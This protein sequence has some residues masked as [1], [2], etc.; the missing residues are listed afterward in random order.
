MKNSWGNVL[1]MHT[2]GE[3]HGPALG[4]VIDGMPAGV[5]YRGDILLQD[6]ARRRPG[7]W[8]NAVTST[9]VSLRQEA[10]I[11]EILSGI[12][13]GQTLGT[14]IAVIVRNQ[15]ARSQDYQNLPPRPGHADEAWQKKFGHVDPRGGGRSS[16]RETLSRVIGGAFAK[17]LLSQVLPDLKVYAYLC[18]IGEVMLPAEERAVV[19]PEEIDQ[20][21]ARFPSPSLQVSVQKL[22][23]EAKARGDSLGASIEV[24][25]RDLPAGL[26]QPVFH[27]LK[28]EL[29]AAMLSVG[30]TYSFELVYDRSPHYGHEFHGQ[31]FSYA[32]IQGG[33]STGEEIRF[34]VGIKPT[35]SIG[36]IAKRGRHDPCIGIRA[37]PVLE[38]MTYFV[39][40]DHWLWSRMD[41]MQD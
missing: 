20:Y 21:I 29:A 32:G 9:G 34:C 17:M 39:L 31:N 38:A 13:A 41:R 22:L 36:E 33:I 12:Y 6:L 35:S 25:I 2:F 24:V 30:A 37:V 11:P 26:G 14:P 8:A 10:D 5:I 16:G 1:L 23:E 4:C 19:V 7:V 3:S 40:A 18:Q 15:D 28:N 27:K